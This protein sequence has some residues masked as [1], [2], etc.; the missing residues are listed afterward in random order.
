MDNLTELHQKI[1]EGFIGQRMIVVPAAKRKLCIKNPLSAQLY[2]TA[3]GYY[4][5][6]SHHDRERP[7]GSDEYILIYCV[8]GK[9]WIKTGDSQCEVLPNTF[10]IIPSHTPHHYGSSAKE[11]WS[12]YWVHFTGAQARLFYDAY[13]RLTKKR[14]YDILYDDNY[15]TEFNYLMNILEGQIGDT[16]TELVYVRM[17][18]LLGSFIYPNHTD[19]LNGHKDIIASIAFMKK[20]ISGN[21]QI[22]DFAQRAN[23]SV[24]RYSELFKKD[25]GYAPMQYYLHLKIHAACQYLCFTGINVKQICNKVGFEDQFYFSRIFK[26]YIGESPLRYRRNIMK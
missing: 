18:N 8:D 25:T 9:G 14:G 15:I 22:K 6:A 3:I 10:Y 4:P 19:Q 20:H 17:L 1:A 5:L 7:S 24:S 16:D 13:T 26:K 21:Y 11:P 12:I 23:Y 2:V